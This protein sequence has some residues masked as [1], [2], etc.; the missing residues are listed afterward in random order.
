MEATPPESGTTPGV[1]QERKQN[2]LGE[3]KKFWFAIIA[4]EKPFFQGAVIFI[5][6]SKLILTIFYVEANV[7][8]P[9]GGAIFDFHCAMCVHTTIFCIAPQRLWV[10]RRNGDLGFAHSRKVGR[11]SFLFSHQGVRQKGIP[12]LHPSCEIR[13]GLNVS[14]TSSEKPSQT[15]P[16]SG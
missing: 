4:T 7:V 3:R 8:N 6:I 12:L 10:F 9:W 2:M 5:Y 14:T 11:A 1:Q 16:I 15:S 13:P